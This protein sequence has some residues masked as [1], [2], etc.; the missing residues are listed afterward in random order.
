MEKIKALE[1]LSSKMRKL[2]FMSFSLLCFIAA[3]VCLIVNI[4]IDRQITWAAYPLISIPFGWAVLAPVLVKNRGMTFLLC[5]LSLLAFPYLYFLSK[6]TPVTDWFLPLGLP[7]AVAG[8]ITCW[9]M[10][11]LFC[12]IKTNI[13]YKAAISVFWLGV[14]VSSIINYFVDIY[15][16]DNPF[17]W[18]NLLNIFA[19]VIAAAVLGILGYSKSNPAK[20]E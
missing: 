19:C 15:V 12:F 14:I 8:V 4:A 18:N 17:R 11:F 13:W 9:F 20:N 7:S 3:G 5:S 6:I 2:I 16:G 1:A 10:F